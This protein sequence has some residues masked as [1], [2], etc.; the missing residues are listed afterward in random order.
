MNCFKPFKFA[1]K[2]KNDSN[3]IKTNDSELD[4]PTW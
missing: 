1:F 4:K 3:M 2:K